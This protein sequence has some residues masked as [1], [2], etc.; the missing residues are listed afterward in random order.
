MSVPVPLGQYYPGDSGV[1]RLD[2]RAKI[3]LAGAFSIALFALSSWVGLLGAAAFAG[4]AVAVSRIP[5]RLAARGLRA[6][7]LLLALTVLLNALRWQPDE[8]LVRLGPIAVD[9]DGL[10]RGLFF[11]ARIALLVFGTT[12]VTYTTSP[13]SLTDGLTRLMRPLRAVRVPVDDV[14]MMLTVALRFIPATAE[15][16]DTI[17]IAQTA[18]GAVFDRGG[19]VAR[20]KAY[21]P[22]LVPLFVALF[23]R[24]D[25]LAVAMESRCYR[26]AGRT[27]AHESSFG[28]WDT[29]AVVVGCAF[30]VLLAVR[31]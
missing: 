23:R 11:A 31:F 4:A 16:A 20:A 21:G 29:A 30:L 8:A 12:L 2:A 14:A 26:G 9:L 19:P 24:A 27:H 7:G 18:R 3:V 17:I 1:H 6:V 22:V 28:A 5:L 15:E 25:E 10:L 13:V